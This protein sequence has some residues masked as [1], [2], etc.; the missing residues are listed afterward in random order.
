MPQNLF[1]PTHQK[2]YG[3]QKLKVFAYNNLICR[4]AGNRTP[5]LRSQTARTTI[6]LHPDAASVVTCESQKESMG[7]R[8]AYLH[9]PHTFFLKHALRAA[10]YDQVKQRCMV[11]SE[12]KNPYSQLNSLFR[13]ENH[14]TAR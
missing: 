3:W 2:F 5:V 14:T 6:M 8:E 1:D 13:A 10:R 12:A 7:R 11:R 4:G 9:S